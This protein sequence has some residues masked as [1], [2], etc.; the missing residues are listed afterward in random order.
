M[1][2]WLVADPLTTVLAAARVMPPGAPVG[3]VLGVGLGLGEG[4]GLGLGV[5]LGPADAVGLGDGLCDGLGVGETL[6]AEGRSAISQAAH[7]RA[8]LSVQ[9]RAPVAPAAARGWSANSCRL[10]PISHASLIPG[11]DVM[12]TLVAAELMPRQPVSLAAPD[13]VVT[14]GTVAEVEDDPVAVDAIPS[15]GEAGSTPE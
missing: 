5:G 13:V 4:L 10:P 1:T 7:S 6:P 3:V 8:E 12:V 14:P 9:V 11:G 2:T 15:V